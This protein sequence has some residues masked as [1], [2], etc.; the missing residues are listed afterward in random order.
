MINP[1]RRF[2]SADRFTMAGLS[3]GYHHQFL[4]S[5]PQTTLPGTPTSLLRQSE[6]GTQVYMRIGGGFTYGNLTPQPVSSSTAHYGFSNEV[7]VGILR[8]V[9]NRSAFYMEF[10]NRIHFF[11]GL[12]EGNFI[13]GPQI[14][15]GIMLGRSPSLVPG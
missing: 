11:P 14:S 10:G 13:G 8:P 4:P 6:S 5:K 2:D 1:E 12:N 9:M 7:Y 15:F 3:A